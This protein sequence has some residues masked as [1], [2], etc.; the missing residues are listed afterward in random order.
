M[1]RDTKTRT[2]TFIKKDDDLRESERRFRIVADFTWD[3]EFWMSPH[4]SFL[5]VSPSCKRISGYAADEFM[6]SETLFLKIVHPDDYE[7][8]QREI[9]EALQQ[10]IQINYDF[11]IICK[12]TSVRWVSLAYQPVTGDNGE[13]LGVRGSIRDVTDRKRLEEEARLLLAFTV[14]IFRTDDFQ[15]ALFTVLSK[16][17]DV[18]GWILGEVWIPRPDG[19]CLECSPVWY[20]RLKSMEK[21]RRLSEIFTFFPGSGLPGRAWAT[22]KAVWIKDVTQDINFP[23]APLARE[24]GIKTGIAIP[25]LSGEEVVAVM[26][27]FLSEPCDEDK[28]KIVVISAIASQLGMIIQRKRMEDDLKKALVQNRQ[29]I[30]S[31]S[32]I[33]IYV[34]ENTRIVKWNKTAE[35]VF[36]IAA[37]DAE[38]TRFS[39]CGIK[40]KDV[41]VVKN[42]LD[43]QY[44]GQPVRIDE[45]RFVYPD[46]KNGFLGL[47][48]SPI[49]TDARIRAGLLIVGSD[50]TKRKLLE[51]QLVQAQ[52][53]E[54]IGQLA[55]GI[56]HEIN[57]PTQYIGDNTRFLQGAFGDMCTLFKK[58]NELLVACMNGNKTEGI[59]REAA[60]IQNKYD[61]EYL[62][63]EIPKAIF[64]SLDG[65]ERVAGIVRAMKDFSHPGT[66]RKTAID[67]NK[68]I[69]STITIARNEWKYV[70]DMKTD[71][72]TSLPL[73]PC[74]PGEF[75][76][77]ILNI[78]INA[79]HAIA[80][81]TGGGIKGKGTIAV[82]SNRDGEWAEIRV[83]D[84]G[85]GIPDAVKTRIF[86]PFFTTKEVGRGTGQGLTIVRNI[87]VE[88]HG[89][90]IT[91]ETETSRGTT[92]IIRLPIGS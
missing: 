7:N 29:I 19:T 30:A 35:D 36:G 12:D 3:W 70:A 89:G 39:G 1:S 46:G 63:E 24:C 60:D 71:F 15:T 65:I 68:A 47:I 62:L 5:Y 18:T 13:F 50:I 67:I 32:S 8:T 25:I 27:F 22:K 77:A 64:Q 73:V 83:E 16:V 2:D 86:D 37:A 84:T 76:Q 56:A 54:S 82:S 92:F 45:V 44:A 66:D 11:R 33:L 59:A 85:T 31:I 72:D 43:C 75:N 17:C 51:S 20:S 55:A 28:S 87:V 41:G 79:A 81:V 26:E 9:K 91:F 78:I 57:T 53:L 23:R 61:I 14:D 49:I 80:D 69:E 6:E 90:T 74:L 52:K 88:K 40:W 42:I 21:F 10:L 48:I 58:Y 4:R 34:D 38:G